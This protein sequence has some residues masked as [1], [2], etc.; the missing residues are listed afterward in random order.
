MEETE[1]S[2]VLGGGVS[3]LVHTHALGKDYVLGYHISW[4]WDNENP[5]PSI[6]LGK[7]SFFTQTKRHTDVFSPGT[8]WLTALSLALWEGDPGDV[9]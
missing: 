4:S 2:Q 8:G 3:G 5:G 9:A 7:L 1:L 6:H